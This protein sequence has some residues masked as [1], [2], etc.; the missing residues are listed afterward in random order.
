MTDKAILYTNVRLKTDVYRR[1][2]ALDVVSEEGIQ[3]STQSEKL[4]RL[5]NV[6]EKF[7]R[8]R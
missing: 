2:V 5:M 6:Y 3:F 7:E 4:A 1:F 8:S